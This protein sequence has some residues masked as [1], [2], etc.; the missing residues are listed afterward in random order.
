VKKSDLFNRVARGAVRNVDFGDFQQLVEVFGFN[1]ARM[2]G[3]H[4]IYAHPDLPE[5]LD[6]QAR[7]GEAKPYQIRQFPQIVEKYGLSLDRKT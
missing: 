4:H 6:L 7:K 5:L 3:S 2:S 1:L